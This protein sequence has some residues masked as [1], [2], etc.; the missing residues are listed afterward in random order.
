[1]SQRLHI[2][3]TDKTH[4]DCVL[5]S[6]E[7]ALKKLCEEWICLDSLG[8]FLSPWK[9]QITDEKLFVELEPVM[10]GLCEALGKSYPDDITFF[11]GEER[12]EPTKKY[13]H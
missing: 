13:D 10:E 5:T 7:N 6:T 2:G 9:V 8:Y 11:K 1:M 4:Y 12:Y 3:V